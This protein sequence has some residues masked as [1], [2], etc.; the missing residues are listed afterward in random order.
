MFKMEEDFFTKLREKVKTNMGN[1]GSHD[2]SHVER[3]YNLA[4]KISKGEKID[5]DI[6]KAATL[7]HDIARGKEDIG[8]IECHAEAGAKLAEEILSEMNFPKDK[9]HA[10]LHCIKV[11]RYS[12]N[13]KAETKEAEIL[14]DADRLDALGAIT[15]ARIF[16]F[17]GYRRNQLHDP[18]R[19]PEEHYYGQETTAIN[20]FYEKI[21]KIRPET[22]KTKKAREIAKER[23]GFVKEYVDR[24]LKEWNGEL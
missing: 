16:M 20:H 5:L 6:V 11:H 1:D 21:F 22:F 17:N 23:Y 14:Q 13:L 2:F 12:K 9:I 18:E 24:F 8:E 4:M 7:L 15:I 10:V 19:K 3:V